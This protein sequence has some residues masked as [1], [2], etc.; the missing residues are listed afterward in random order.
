MR[1]RFPLLS[2]CLLGAIALVAPSAEAKNLQAATICGV[3][4]CIDVAPADLSIELVEGSFQSSAPDA[5]EPWYR[6]RVTVGDETVHESWRL[7]VLPQG[8]Y[9]TTPGDVDTW[10]ELNAHGASLYRQLTAALEP[11]PAAALESRLARAEPQVSSA[12]PPPPSPPAGDT[13]DDAGDASI[14]IAGSAAAAILLIGAAVV[15]L[16][17]RARSA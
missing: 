10:S 13:Q 5:A 9:T 1:H 14:A 6:V 11:F 17:R 16:R 3:D 12:T 15:V 8:G 4:R 7:I 2:V